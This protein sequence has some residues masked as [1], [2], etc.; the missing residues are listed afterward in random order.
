M[1][2]LN[3]FYT[4]I[5][6]TTF[7]RRQDIIEELSDDGMLEPGQILLLKREPE[8][9]YD[10]NA[11]SVIHPDTM[12]QL[13]FIGKD[14]ASTMAP[15]MDR[16]VKYSVEVNQVTGG[17]GYSYGINITVREG[18]VPEPKSEEPQ[19]IE[20]KKN[21]E[22]EEYM[23]SRKIYTSVCEWLDESGFSYEADENDGAILMS[24]IK[25]ESAIGKINIF[26]R[27][28][29]KDMI[30]YSSPVA[31]AVDSANLMSVGELC[32]RVNEQYL[33]PTFDID[34]SDN[35]ISA[36]TFF[37]CG[38]RRLEENDLGHKMAA[39]ALH[40]QKYGNAL[41]SVS[42]GFQSPVEALANIKED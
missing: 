41:V 31:F 37:P 12:Q 33:F 8:N 23:Y 11:I 24:G 39:T 26:I 13:G 30:F 18:D 15:N 1:K 7:D 22:E 5:A 42:L 19:Y 40:F 34:F 21:T 9:P 3:S 6:G 20:E 2:V 35:S 16:G 38:D 4:K 17:T 10:R 27:V 36:K 32:L 28:R 25:V 29:E 14:L